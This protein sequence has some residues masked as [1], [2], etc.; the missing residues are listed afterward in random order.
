MIAWLRQLSIQQRLWV[1]VGVVVTGFILLS[2]TALSQLHTSLLAQKYEKNRQVVN[3]A[4]S[5]IEHYHRKVASDELTEDAAMQAAKDAIKALR[6]EGQNYFWLQDDEPRMIMHPFKPSLDGNSL[7]NTTDDNGKRFFTEMAQLV[8]TQGDGF[9][10]YVWPKPN[11]TE[12][13]EKISYVKR[14]GPWGWTIGSGIYI[15]QVQEVY[16]QM[17]NKVLFGVIVIAFIIV[18]ISILLGKS[19]TE[20][21]TQTADRM[22]DVS[23]GEGDLTQRLPEQGQDEVSRLARHFN[24]FLQTMQDSLRQV[25]DT[26]TQVQ[27][28]ANRIAEASCESQ[29]GSQRQCDATTS[30][31]A[32]MEQMTTSIKESAD[33]ASSADEQ[34]NQARV[35]TDSSKQLLGITI[36]DIDTLTNN[37]NNASD[38]ISNVAKES[39]NIGSVLDVIRSIAEQTNLLALN[40]AIEAARAGE[41]GRGFAV[42]ADEV[43]TLASRTGQSTEEIQTMIE[44]LQKGA[45]KAVEAISESQSIS[46]HTKEQAAKAGESLDEVD[47]RILAASQMNSLISTGTVHQANAIDEVNSRLDELTSMANSANHTADQLAEAGTSLK[48]SSEQLTAIVSRFKLS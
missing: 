2:W 21:I 8:A 48:Q 36:S 26:S 18:A 23:Q 14:F 34:S 16:A 30:V 39:D 13:T 38:V 12:A 6:Y 24:A 3:V 11:E 47:Q 25:A 28:Q 10:P 35:T 4:F 37:I 20:P 46:E 33:N 32:A 17:R 9:V 45:S 40:A 42:V 1:N 27:T 31:A 15:D 22:K 41:Q 43:R 44:A 19:I 5:V 7:V 29:S